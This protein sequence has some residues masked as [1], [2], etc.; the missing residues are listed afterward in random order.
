MSHES[1]LA[2]TGRTMREESQ[3]RRANNRANG[4]VILAQNGVR[5]QSKNDGAHLIIMRG[6][7]VVADYWP[8]TGKWRGRRQRVSGRGVF[9]LIQWLGKLA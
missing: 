7:V 2:E 9:K 5:Y 6:D 1:D 4:P 8:G 3:Q